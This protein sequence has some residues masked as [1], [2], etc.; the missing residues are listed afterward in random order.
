M[1]PA[2]PL[3]INSL[4]KKLV[5]DSLVGD[6]VRCAVFV[7]V[8]DKELVWSFEKTTVWKTVNAAW[9]LRVSLSVWV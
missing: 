6:G 9:R 2:L 7:C 1:I 4:L 8:R 3:L 5:L